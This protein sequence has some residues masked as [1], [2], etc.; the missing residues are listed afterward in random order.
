MGYRRENG[1]VGIRNHV[2]ILPLD[3]L[4]NAAARRWR[5]C[6]KSARLG[7]Y[8]RG[9]PLSLSLTGNLSAKGVISRSVTAAPRAWR[10]RCQGKTR[11]E[12]QFVDIRLPDGNLPGDVFN[13]VIAGRQKV[14]QHY[15]VSRAVPD[16]RVDTF[17]DSRLAS[18]RKQHFTASKRSAA[19]DCR[20]AVSVRISSLDVVRR[21]PWATRSRARL[22]E[23]RCSAGL[24][25]SIA[26]GLYLV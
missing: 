5:M 1:H 19:I 17:R 20:R 14:R 12:C 24:V 4:S 15:D 10:Q 11:S 26:F 7:K 3:D 2:I 18:S 25:C 9:K 8:T 16:Q 22:A 23:S 6:D 21:L 13:D